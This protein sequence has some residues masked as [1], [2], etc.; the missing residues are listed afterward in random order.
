MLQARLVE[1][2]RELLNADEHKVPQLALEV[3]RLRVSIL[4]MNEIVAGVPDPT[5]KTEIT[6]LSK[7]LRARVEDPAEDEREV[8]AVKAR[9]RLRETGI[10][11]DSA[12][13]LIRGLRALQAMRPIA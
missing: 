11:P 2:N 7:M 13:A 8:E 3:Q 10:D 9:S 1:K 12:E 5:I 4:S 6:L